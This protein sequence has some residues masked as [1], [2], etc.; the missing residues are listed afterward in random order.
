[1]FEYVLLKDLNDS[2]ED[3]LELSKILKNTNCKI[4]LIPFNEIFGVYKRP[5]HD[6]IIKFSKILH[7]NKTNYRVFIRWSRGEDI[8]AAC[9]QL[10][11][12]NE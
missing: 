7:E 2:E 1:M 4:N 3:A 12:K 9:G 11:T 5:S 8:N 10:A 6:R